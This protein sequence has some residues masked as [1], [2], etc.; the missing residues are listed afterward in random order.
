[1]QE[2]VDETRKVGRNQVMKDKEDKSKNFNS[3]K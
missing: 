1:M 2:V 3:R